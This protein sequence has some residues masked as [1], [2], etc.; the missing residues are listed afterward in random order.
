M[1]QERLDEW[2]F[3]HQ[4]LRDNTHAYNF[5]KMLRVIAAKGYEA[6]MIIDAQDNA[7]RRERQQLEPQLQ[8]V[9]GVIRGL[10]VMN[11]VR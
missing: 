11:M 1:I 10:D 7:R 6:K 9:E 8:Y 5:W 4:Y 2:R 3:R